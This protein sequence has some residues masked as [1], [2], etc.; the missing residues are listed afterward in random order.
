[1]SISTS[2][3]CPT[4][5]PLRFRMMSTTLMSFSLSSLLMFRLRFRFSS[6]FIAF[7]PPPVPGAFFLAGVAAAGAGLPLRLAS[8][9]C[10]FSMVRFSSSTCRPPP[11]CSDAPPPPDAAAGPPGAPAIL[12]NCLSIFSKETPRAFAHSWTSLPSQLKV[13]ALDHTRR[14]SSAHAST[15]SYSPSSSFCFT[16]PRSI[17]CAMICGYS[18][19]PRA[20]KSTG[21]LK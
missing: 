7:L 5:C 6:K 15:D 1:M 10:S 20:S 4:M 9:C 16:V 14:M 11:P 18:G 21:A 3:V 12:G 19:M 13:M 8:S 17:G 2:S